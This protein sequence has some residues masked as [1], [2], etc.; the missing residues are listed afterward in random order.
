MTT[1]EGQGGYTLTFRLEY[2]N[3]VGMLGK[4]T[5][6][7]GNMGGDIN[8]VDLVSTGRGKIVRDLT[9]NCQ[10]A[11]HGQQIMRR[12]RRQAGIS[13][14]YVLDPTFL[15]H[16]GGKIALESR[17]R[18][19]TRRDLSMVYTPGVGRVSQYIAD[20]PEGVWRLTAKGNTVAVVTDGT[21]VLGLGDIGPAA[22]LPVMEG[23]AILFKELAGVDAWPIAL[24][25]KDPDQIVDIVKAS[26]VGFGGINLE[27][28]SA[29]RCFY[30]EERLRNELDIPVFHDD[31]HGTA[32]VVLAG[33]YNALKVVGKDISEIKAVMVGAGAGRVATARIL[34]EAGLKNLIAFDRTGPI[35]TG[36][37]V[38]DHIGT[39]WLA[40]NSNPGNFQGNLL[41]AFDDADLFVGLS[42]PN[43]IT[44]DHIKR[45]N[46]DAIVFALANP[47]PEIR[48]EEALPFV[49][50]MATGRSDFANQIN[51]ALC[52]PGLFRGVLDVRADVI[53]EEMKIAAANAIANTVTKRAL[54]EENIIPSVFD[55]NVVP[56][57]A[58]A[59]AAA[60][61]KTGVARRPRRR[62][63][64]ASLSGIV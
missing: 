29:P 18:V 41:E 20:N 60:A 12:L 38:G 8:G 43:L 55:R 25:T 7:I 36:R 61:R 42:G 32:V 1:E 11:E 40:E 30:I 9:V 57:V 58:K 34:V 5:T 21:A 31:Q 17:I 23:K 49:R 14:T 19:E 59:V 45:M 3:Q 22:S 64:A 50:V 26:R 46:S 39:Q 54:S 48:P 56:A 10:D 15:A 27:D 63:M 53:N 52:F 47:D 4:V 51:N 62:T 37:D 35:H 6:T 33:V 28:I 13:V 16:S 44:Q 24:D 2:A